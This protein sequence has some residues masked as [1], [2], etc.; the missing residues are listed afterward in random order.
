MFNLPPV[1]SLITISPTFWGLLRQS[2]E[3]DASRTL[4]TESSSGAEWEKAVKEWDPFRTISKPRMRVL[5]GRMRDFLKHVSKAWRP[6]G[7]GEDVQA[8][9]VILWRKSIS[10]SL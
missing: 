2:Q 3:D 8:K 4:A 6:E 5:E 10:V 1:P 9:P 7:Q